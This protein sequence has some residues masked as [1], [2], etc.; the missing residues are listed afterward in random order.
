MPGLPA[1]APEDMGR[2]KTLGQ[3]IGF[4]SGPRSE[5]RP[6]AAEPSRIESD[7]RQPL[8]DALLGVVSELTGYPVEMLGLEM[9]IE[10]DLGIDSIKRV[11]ILST[12]EGKMPG[13]PAVAPEDMGRLKTLGQ[14]IA[15]LSGPRCPAPADPF[16]VQRRTACAAPGNKPPASAFM[17]PPLRDGRLAQRQ[18]LAATAAPKL[19][20]AAM[21]IPKGRKVFV[22]DDRAGLSQAITA[23]LGNLGAS[24]VLVSVDILKYKKDLPHAAGLVIVQKPAPT[25]PEADLRNAFELT[26]AL[27]ADLVDSARLGGAFFTTVTRLDGAFGLNGRQIHNPMQ[28][29]L[30]GLAKTAAIEW[31]EVRCRAL[32][33]S[34]DWNDNR[35]VARAVV[36]E[37]MARGPIEIG[38][39]PEGRQ[40]L[41]LS[42]A[43]YPEGRLNLNPGD[44]VVISG[45]ARGITA[46]CTIELA[47]RVR[48]TLI[49]LG[50]S[51]EPVPEPDWLRPIEDDTS[52]KKALLENEFSAASAKPAEVESRLR[53]ILANREIAR[54]LE[55]LASTGA[56][57]RYYAVDIRDPERVAG[58]LAEAR[59]RHGPIRGLI[60]GAGVLEDRLIVD[61]RAEQFDRVFDTKVIGLQSLMAAM[62]ADDLRYVIFF[63]S[64]T[65]RIGNKGQAAYAMANEALNKM[66]V[67]ESQRRPSCRVI[68][69]NWGPWQGG[70]VT[71]AL[72]REFER[73][74]VALLPVA[75]GVLS[76]MQEMTGDAGLPAEVVIGSLLNPAR[77]ETTPE[78]DRPHLSILFERE[79]DVAT[80]PILKSHVIDGKPVV[81]MA[82][83]AEWFGH[84]ALHEN[85]GLLLR[86]LEDLRIL[87]GIRLGEESKLIRVLAGKARRKEG[88]YEVDLELRN[89]VR[90]GK[91]VL[92]S[93]AR[94]ILAEDYDHPPAYR[95]PE[96][97]SCNHYPRSAAEIYEKILFHG[98]HLHGLRGIQCCTADGMVAEVAGAPDPEHWIASPLRNAWL[99]DPL[100]LDSAF[101]MASLWCYDQHGC[102]SLPSHAAS[103]RQFRAAFPAQGVTVAL[104]VREATAK[105]MR[106]DFTFLDAD[107]QVIAQLTGYEAVMDPLL[108][109]AFKK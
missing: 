30:A 103:Y 28:G 17:E 8:A 5:T 91:D 45:G 43:P 11:E 55:T 71:A 73:Q 60:H 50:R 21:A 22:T 92:H 104:E 90:E 49:L 78:K 1:I 57:A 46:A 95:L 9:D 84:G 94:A 77:A 52:I 100:V 24:T 62:P 6:C 59:A 23:E 107:G 58:I 35:A 44:V 18:V 41:T 48:P 65:A 7:D 89:G 67:A 93:R 36:K 4:L 87:N 106:G 79:I 32:D 66:A 38:L 80:H 25:T 61:T 85:P 51:P 96:A 15:H 3:I 26:Q 53:Q 39:R 40:A 74:R 33:I 101:Q 47:R 54:T 2:L 14:I 31:P 75:D 37:L 64:V 19:A 68:A 10:A 70:M 88:F 12:L 81:P 13:L 72:K 76:L 63:S 97:L 99:C 29:A 27:G 56:S 83:I 82:L 109:R 16:P 20:N 98:Q 69:I 108:N 86:G 105:R 34:P 42:A 102:V